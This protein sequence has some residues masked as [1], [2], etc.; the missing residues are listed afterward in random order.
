MS[1]VEEQPAL[2][3]R[4]ALRIDWAVKAL[5]AAGDLQA[6]GARRAC[7]VVED[8]ADRLGHL[9]AAVRALHAPA[10]P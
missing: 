7:E 1:A 9:A 5:V 6:V 2:L 8:E 3:P 10:K 4:A